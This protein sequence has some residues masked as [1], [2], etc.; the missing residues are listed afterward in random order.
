MSVTKSL[1]LHFGIIICLYIV[2]YTDELRTPSQPQ[3]PSLFEAVSASYSLSALNL[4][5][6]LPVNPLSKST[7]LK[8]YSAALQPCLR[9]GSFSIYGEDCIRRGENRFDFG[10]HKLYFHNT[11]GKILFGVG[12]GYNYDNKNYVNLQESTSLNGN[13]VYEKNS[14]LDI[15][16]WEENDIF[17]NVNGTFN[18]E[19]SERFL[20]GFEMTHCVK[21]GVEYSEKVEYST[22]VYSAFQD[23]ITYYN[24]DD[25]AY[26]NIL[27]AG[28]GLL[29]EY[30]SK[31]RTER[32]RLLSLVYKQDIEHSDL[33]PLNGIRSY[34][35]NS[36]P[37]NVQFSGKNFINRSLGFN[38][39]FSER[40]PDKV[41]LE[42]THR[43]KVKM[44]LKY[45]NFTLQYEGIKKSILSINQWNMNDLYYG[46]DERKSQNFPLSLSIHNVSDCILF[47]HFRLRFD[48]HIE[49][50]VELYSKEQI[51]WKCTLD[52]TPSLGF[53]IP[54]KDIAVV[55]IN[56]F[57]SPVKTGILGLHNSPEFGLD[58]T[59]TSLL[60]LRI[61]ILK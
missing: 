39:L 19:N 21:H 56:Y 30:I 55:D 52:F 38:I 16:D 59:Y 15:N 7:E 17:V 26:R 18:Y 6:V 14:F 13:N 49:G 43:K 42:N 1:W 22:D 28:T 24:Y 12:A 48:S 36:E 41:Y 53:T 11:I 47:G 31:R 9:A 57:F 60:Q 2:A 45:L 37:D 33:L 44:Y 32:F 25:R 10:S 27:S 46:V 54:V 4:N 58:I 3:M 23:N 61:A 50:M 8:F 29:H 35:L 34:F 51:G 5:T 20:F 40:S